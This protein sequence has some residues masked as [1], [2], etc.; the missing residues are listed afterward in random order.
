M[1]WGLLGST[2]RSQ[3]KEGQGRPDDE[4]GRHS[5]CHKIKIRKYKKRE[6][7]SSLKYNSCEQQFVRK[8]AQLHGVTELS[9]EEF[10]AI[11]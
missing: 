6:V 2:I 8:S 7:I 4:N 5:S 1:V 10:S 9:G 11:E 3:A